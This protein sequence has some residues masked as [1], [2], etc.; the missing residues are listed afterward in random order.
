MIIEI[1]EP[2]EVIEKVNI[3]NVYIYKSNIQIESFPI[4]IMKMHLHYSIV[5]LCIHRVISSTKVSY[6]YTITALVARF[7]YKVT[8][9][10]LS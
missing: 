5:F 8:I 3:I 6:M 9:V 10:T 7:L 2:N 4:G 1:R